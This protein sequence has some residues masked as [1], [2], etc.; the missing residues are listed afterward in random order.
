MWVLWCNTTKRTK[1]APL[2]SM[3]W[4]RYAKILV[5]NKGKSLDKDL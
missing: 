5:L 3:G 4:N 1:G 2:L